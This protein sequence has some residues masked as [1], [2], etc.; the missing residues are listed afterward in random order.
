MPGI[1]KT[2]QVHFSKDK[3]GVGKGRKEVGNKLQMHTE[4]GADEAN[5][6]M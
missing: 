5:S 6:G 1:I 4:P 3:I 2:R